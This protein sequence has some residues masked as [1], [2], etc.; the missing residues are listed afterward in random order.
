MATAGLLEKRRLGIT[1]RKFIAVD[2]YVAVKIGDM[3]KQTKSKRVVSGRALSS[4]PLVDEAWHA[5]CQAI[6]KGVEEP[7]WRPVYY[8][9]TQHRRVPPKIHHRVPFH[10]LTA[11]DPPRYLHSQLPTSPSVFGDV[12]T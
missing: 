1:N 10:S 4:T 6:Y 3:E 8:L 2:N 7:E 12:Y 11:F 9:K 5:I